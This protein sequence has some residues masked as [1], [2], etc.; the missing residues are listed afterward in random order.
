MSKINFDDVKHYINY[1]LGNEN[2]AVSVERVMEIIKHRVLTKVPNSSQ[3]IKG[4]INFRGEI[5]PVID[6]HR[7]FNMVKDEEEEGMIVV[8]NG[9]SE[10][11]NYHIGLLVDEVEDVIEFKYK[12]L[13][14]SP[15]MGINYDLSFVDGI[16]DID[17]RFIMVLNIEKVLNK[18]ELAELKAV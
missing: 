8:I 6:M 10:K 4:V 2:F 15:D 5:V 14:K 18:T 7:R 11:S 9:D 16:I 17:D 1:R 12:D 3:Y 13:R